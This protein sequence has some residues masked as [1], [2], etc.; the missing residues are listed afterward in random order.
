[1]H[2]LFRL[3]RGSVD[4]QLEGAETARF[5]NACTQAGIVL[6]RAE[7][8]DDFTLHL[9][10][11]LRELPRVREAAQRSGCTLRA[12]NERGAPKTLRRL[13]GRRAL[14]AAGLLCVLALLWSSL[15]VW[16]LDLSGCTGAAEPELL[17][18]LDSAQVS[19]GSFWPAFSNERIR[20][21]VLRELP[22]LSW[23]AVQMY[24]SRAVVALR[25]GV[26]VPEVCD[27]RMPA[28]IVAGKAGLVTEVRA[29]QGTAA[30]RPGST[31]LAGETLVSAE[32]RSSYEKAGVRLVHAR[33]EVYARTW[34]SLSAC[35]PL[36]RTEKR[37][38]GR[39]K[40][41]LALILGG[42]RINFYDNSRNPEGEYDKLTT[43]YMLSVPGVFSLPLGLAVER[44]RVCEGVQ[45]GQD[46]GALRAA[47]QPALLKRLRQ[48]IGETG[49]IRES[50][51]S[52]S[53][54]DG[55][56]YVTLRAECVE[57]IARERSLSEE[58]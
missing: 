15:Y 52:A 23:M 4:A 29:L 13:R 18:A 47:L 7:P 1:M 50:G 8:L 37:P 3:L 43:T 32:M 10:M 49:E 48:E 57:D 44:L 58:N 11:D 38:T 27:T 56:L 25:Q 19:I 17:A 20:S 40:L 53:E 12:V 24:G 14:G 55:M 51:F 5:L 2:R 9:R 16:E 35:A 34:Y 31:V 46:R 22:Q 30:V 6:H 39:E 28:E 36:T 33:A 42:R 41:H 21:R 26:P 54:R 45:A